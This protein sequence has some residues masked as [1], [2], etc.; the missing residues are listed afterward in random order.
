MKKLMFVAMMATLSLN[1]MAAEGDAVVD[2]RNITW[3]AH[4][5]SIVS[6]G[7]KLEFVRDRNSLQKNAYMIP[8]DELT[9]GSAK[10][11]HID[12]LFNEENR[13]YKVWMEGGFDQ[14]ETMEFI[15]TYK[16]GDAKNESD[17]DGVH[18]KQ[19]LVKDVIFTLAVFG[20]TRFE[21]TIESRFQVSLD[22]KK[23]TSVD[24]F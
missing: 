7:K 10:L 14:L 8:G 17:V 9:I 3:G 20:E 23:N 13:F 11:N 1:L 5:D 6:D 16:F 12:Y 18:Y 2:F 24:D 21:L 22:Y 15:L 19:W 4:K